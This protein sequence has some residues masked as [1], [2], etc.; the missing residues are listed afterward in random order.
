MTHGLVID[1][2]QQ[3]GEVLLVT[4]ARAPAAALPAAELLMQLLPGQP[5]S[6]LKQLDSL[7]QVCVCCVCVCVCSVRR[8]GHV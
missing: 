5:E 7:L 8:R 1:A 4:A 6:L 2:E 3:L